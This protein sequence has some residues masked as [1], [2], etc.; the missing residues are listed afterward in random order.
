[1]AL[2]VKK[3]GGSSVAD[4]ECMRRVARRIG[5]ARAAGDRVVVVVSAMGKTTDQLIDL[6]REVN[7]Q[8]SDREMDML[9]ST[10][11]Q[12]SSAILTMAL[13]ADGY[14]AVSLTGGQ[15]GIH[16]DHV[17][18]KAKIQ[19][20]EPD[21][22][23]AHLAEGRIVIVA[24]FQGLTPEMD[25]ATLGRGGSDTT[26]VALAAAL[27]A[28]RCKIYTDVDGVFTA[29]PR[30]VKNAV[31]L[32]EIS[33]DE[34]LEL[35]SLG[36]KV[37]QSRAVE[38]AKKYDVELEVLSS[39]TGAPGTVLRS[40]VAN[41]EDI[42]VR[43]VAV[44]KN[45]AK[46]TIRAVSDRPG[47]AAT[48]FRELS[49]ANTNVD[50]IVQNVSAEGHTDISF[51]VPADDL[52]KS[53][54]VVESIMEKVGAT[55]VVVDDDIAKVS[56][57]GVGMRGHSGVAARMFEALAAEDINIDMIA[58]SEIKISVGI[59]GDQA[60]QAMDVLHNAFELELSA[61]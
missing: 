58:T 32:D 25:V 50:M 57:V 46:L 2:I 35:A 19:R 8:P 28:D 47:A 27:K 14:E 36:A 44:D 42:V 26:A 55:S 16:T 22:I 30:V 31:K 6:A 21:N 37:L 20:I 54:K 38:F 15:A 1:M 3:F 10:G 5:E 33:Y 23:H 11:E 56:I 39:F 4:A 59:R 29:D 9:M 13:Q 61:S 40:E 7:P 51:S 53:K 12:I 41:M 52:A 18:T 34:M 17:H 60:D 49:V 43:G 24:G 45:Q 48:I